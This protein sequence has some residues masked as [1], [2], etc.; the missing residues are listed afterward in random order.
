MRSVPRLLEAT[1]ARS[2]H[3]LRDRQLELAFLS[4]STARG[5]P[6]SPDSLVYVR[7]AGPDG[8]TQERLSNSSRRSP[9]RSAAQP[10][11]ARPPRRGRSGPVRCTSPSSDHASPA[12]VRLRASRTPRSPGRRR[13]RPPRPPSG[14][15][16]EA[17]REPQDEGVSAWRRESPESRADSVVSSSDGFEPGEVADLERCER[18]LRQKLEA[19]RVVLREEE[20]RAREQVHGCRHVP[21]ANARL[22]AGRERRGRA[23]AEGARFARS[24]ARAREA[25]GTPARGGSPRI[26]SY[27]PGR[28]AALDSNQS[29]SRSCSSARTAFGIAW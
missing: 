28:S 13:A 7:R 29:A 10:P 19:V 11:S 17:H 14:F 6:A 15:G 8:R 25:P 12:P 9:V 21:R 26:S 3:G 18:E 20:P 5:R 16:P 22:P 24:P 23:P 1:E 2:E 27:S 4:P